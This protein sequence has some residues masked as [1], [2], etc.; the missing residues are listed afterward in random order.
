[1][2]HAI[3]SKKYLGV[4]FLIFLQVVCIKLQAD[5]ID[6]FTIDA[7]TAS[8]VELDTVNNINY[9]FGGSAGPCTT[10]TTTAVCNSCA[11]KT[12][13]T[14]TACNTR[15]V[16]ANLPLTIRL[17]IK[18]RPTS[19]TPEIIAKN[20]NAT[21]TSV[22]YSDRTNTSAITAGSEI[23]IKIPW[24]ALATAASSSTA[25]C[26]LNGS[27]SC[28]N[29][30]FELTMD[31]GVTTD[32]TNID[33]N[34]KRQFRIRYLGVDA[35]SFTALSL[36]TATASAY[37]G[38]C[39]L[40]VYPGDQKVY[41]QSPSAGGNILTSSA[42]TFVPSSIPTDVKY[43]KIR[44]FYED[45]GTATTISN[46]T[47]SFN[48]FK[49]LDLSFE[50]NSSGA[51]SGA[52]IGK[53]A[54]DGLTNG[55]L[56]K[57]AFATVDKAQNVYWIPNSTTLATGT[58]NQFSATPSEVVGLLK[59]QKCF[60]AT[61]AYGSELDARVETFRQFRNKFLLT[62][63]Y[64]IQFV[65]FYYQHSPYFA[66]K[67]KNNETLKTIVQYY[68][69]PLLLVIQ[70]IMN[71]IWLLYIS[72][73]VVVI[74]LFNKNNKKLLLSLCISIF[75]LHIPD[76]SYAQ[77][78]TEQSIDE[79]FAD[80]EEAPPAPQSQQSPKAQPE[81]QLEQE[82]DTQTEQFQ[83]QI[84]EPEKTSNSIQSQQPQA[85][86]QEEKIQENRFPETVPY[87]NQPKAPVGG[88]KVKVN[89]PRSADGLLRIEKDGTYVYK[90]EKKEKSRSGY[91]KFSRSD[92][93]KISSQNTSNANFKDVY[94]VSSITEISFLYE[95][96]PFTSFGKM[97]LQ[98]GSGLAS[99]TGQGRFVSGNNA[100]LSAQEK[101]TMYMIPL[102][103]NL[104]YRFEYSD[105]QWFVP[106][107]YGGTSLYMLAEIRD[108]NRRPGFGTTSTA[109]GGGGLMVSLSRWD[110][111]GA[112]ALASEYNISDM[113]LAFD[114]QR[115]Q[116][117]NNQ[118]DF[119]SNT[120]SVALVADF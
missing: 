16:F 31:V 67:I 106:Y 101:Y 69:W 74:F 105:K 63:K 94:S 24:S 27:S 2:K 92:A 56:Y 76:T 111:K 20:A 9:I 23:F 120:L 119:T 86:A 35:S 112:H 100:N 97:G 11:D 37:I 39:N 113:W 42:G 66:D 40:S 19:G 41:I 107:A 81:L 5:E 43:T 3:K 46:Y 104:I 96:Q 47:L 26:D 18:S 85:K 84:S 29:T 22:S 64:G 10:T 49:D 59:T 53:G 68:L 93:P 52:S 51:V 32:G 65:K 108:D 30:A 103:A 79:E 118:I 89:H 90:T 60:I 116:G 57:F 34:Y 95:W 61:A 110:A 50:T 88:G 62:N 54:I 98:L 78:S 7:D 17:K 1:M 102:A 36:C 38:I 115:R 45:L 33:A 13:D 91:F 48:S 114:Y 87:F 71:P 72:L 99:V 14:V 4:L 75:C 12:N 58:A 15:S 28:G 44:I 82:L 83:Q 73:F 21:T 6:T 8:L 77:T 117:L 80:L 70:V 55:N 109:Q 25:L